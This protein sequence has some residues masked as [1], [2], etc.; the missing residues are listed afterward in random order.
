MHASYLFSFYARRLPWSRQWHPAHSSAINKRHRPRTECSP[1]PPWDTRS[2][3]LFCCR[4][5]PLAQSG[6]IV[7]L[8]NG[9]LVICLENTADYSRRRP[10]ASEINAKTSACR[11]GA[12]APACCVASQAVGSRAPSI[13][14]SRPNHHRLRTA[15]TYWDRH[16][17]RRKESRWPRYSIAT[18]LQS[19]WRPQQPL[20]VHAAYAGRLGHGR[21]SDLDLLS[22][23]CIVARSL[24]RPSIS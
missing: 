11:R 17:T 9:A 24:Q 14:A 15:P 7:L 6:H 3:G 20:D 21:V 5:L 23:H 1:A 16:G 18:V 4:L 19:S 13:D 10:A 22:D 12:H 8:Y 2:G